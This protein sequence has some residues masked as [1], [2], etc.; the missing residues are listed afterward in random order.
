MSYDVK[1]FGFEDVVVELEVTGNAG[2]H[3][4]IDEAARLS[5]VRRAS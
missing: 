3:L 1:P 2:D 5:I 4:A